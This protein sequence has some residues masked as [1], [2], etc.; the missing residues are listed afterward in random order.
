MP[1][2][3]RRQRPREPNT[4]T[5]TA[6]P[7]STSNTRRISAI[8]L[9]G[10]SPTTT[11]PPYRSNPP[12]PN[13]RT[14]HRPPRS[15]SSSITSPQPST[16]RSPPHQAQEPPSISDEALAQLL[17]NDEYSLYQPVQSATSQLATLSSLLA[18]STE[19]SELQ[20]Y[21]ILYGELRRGGASSTRNQLL[22]NPLNYAPQGMDDSYEALLELG[23]RIG[24]AHS[25]L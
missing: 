24:T 21:G 2:E 23:D 3:T 10:D 25:A 12:Q 13:P 16:S 22:T 20:A 7:I 11:H 5:V 19:D 15:Y 17:Q 6:S 14:T 8:D 1:K 18:G 4:H 9:T